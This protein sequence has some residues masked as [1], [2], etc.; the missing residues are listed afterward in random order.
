MG[1]CLRRGR[2]GSSH[3]LPLK[4]AEWILFSRP[5]FAGCIHFLEAL[6]TSLDFMVTLQQAGTKGKEGNPEATQMDGQCGSAP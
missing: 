6:L 3:E 1:A 2:A 5:T 4:E